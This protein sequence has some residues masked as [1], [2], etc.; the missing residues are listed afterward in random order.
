MEA[1]WGTGAGDERVEAAG[2]GGGLQDGTDKRRRLG[3]ERYLWVG[4][5]MVRADAKI[6]RCLE[7]WQ[8]LYHLG[9]DTLW[10]AGPLQGF[11]GNNLNA[12]DDSILWEQCMNF[13]EF[14]KTQIQAGTEPMPAFSIP[15]LLTHA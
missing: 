7:G 4:R 11:Q 10:E 1:R 12:M 2:L 15:L 13:R 14:K 9:G 5:P 3:V 6:G 8:L